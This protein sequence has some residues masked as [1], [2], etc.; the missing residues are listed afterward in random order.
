MRLEKNVFV[1]SGC[2]ATF[3][4]VL[5]NMTLLQ[6][7][8]VELPPAA[9]LLHGLVMGLPRNPGLSPAGLSE[10]ARGLIETVQ[11]SLVRLRFDVG[12]IDG[13]LGPQTRRAIL[14]FEQRHGLPKTGRVSARLLSKLGTSQVTRRMSMVSP[15]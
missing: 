3:I 10:T 9:E 7:Q 14:A 4:S 1:L 13:R 2:A 5:V 15:R 8:R 11:A 12:G 6:A